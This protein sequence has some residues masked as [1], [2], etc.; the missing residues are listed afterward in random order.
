MYLV[1]GSCRHPTL[2]CSRRLRNSPKTAKNTAFSSHAQLKSLK[3]AR[4]L[5]GSFCRF[6]RAAMFPHPLESVA[7]CRYVT[8]T[9]QPVFAA[10]LATA[11]PKTKL[12]HPKIFHKVVVCSGSITLP[13]DA[14]FRTL[15]HRQVACRFGLR[16]VIT[17]YENR[18]DVRSP[19]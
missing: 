11:G 5:H 17:A 8:R 16:K 3:P 1:F 7:K 10:R 12:A 14:S 9:R 2:A 6:Q 15:P 13:V 4:A 19:V 18:A